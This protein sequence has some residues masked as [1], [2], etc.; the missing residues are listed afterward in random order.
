MAF[1]LAKF[2]QE[3]GVALLIVALLIG[4]VAYPWPTRD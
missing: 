4:M 3:F 2:A 1:D